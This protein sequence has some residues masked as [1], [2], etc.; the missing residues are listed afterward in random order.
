MSLYPPEQLMHKATITEAKALIRYGLK[1]PTII[2]VNIAMNDG[3]LY[4]EKS[5]PS[6]DM[7]NWKK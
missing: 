2:Q 7:L 3:I 4:F 6:I 5:Q 1:N